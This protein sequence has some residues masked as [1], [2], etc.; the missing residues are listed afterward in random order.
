[1]SDTLTISRRPRSSAEV[2]PGRVLIIDDE[3]AIRESLQ[4]LLE[5]EGYQVICSDTGEEGL[6]A[7]SD[8]TFDVILLD[9]ALPGISGME[10]LRDLRAHAPNVVVVMITAYGT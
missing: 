1:M 10:V 4:T 8:S 7:A 5:I 2:S 9:L 3:A 6:L